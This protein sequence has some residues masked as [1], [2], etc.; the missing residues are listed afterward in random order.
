MSEH[1]TA[2]LSELQAVCQRILASD[3]KLSGGSAALTNM[4]SVA[5]G[6][7]LANS[8]EALRRQCVDNHEQV[9]ELKRSLDTHRGVIAGDSAANAKMLVGLTRAVESLV[10]GSERERTQT[11]GQLSDLIRSV[12]S[13]RVGL[14][15]FSANSRQQSAELRGSV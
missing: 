15:G 7:A 9:G 13:L 6:T 1:S 5:N 3:T 14:A 12:E 8:L 2:L 11:T 10:E 4:A